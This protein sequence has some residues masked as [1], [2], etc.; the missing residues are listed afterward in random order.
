M[1]LAQAAQD[2]VRAAPVVGLVV[3]VRRAGGLLARDLVPAQREADNV[4]AEQ[5]ER[6]QPR[7]ERCRVQPRVVLDPVLDPGRGS[8]RGGRGKGRRE[9]G[10][11]ERTTHAS[12]LDTARERAWNMGLRPCKTPSRY[13]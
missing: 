2:G 6:L 1:M 11:D 3:R 9:H 4:R 7:L 10:E 12:N 13:P 8:C 5:V